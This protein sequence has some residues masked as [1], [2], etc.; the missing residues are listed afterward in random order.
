MNT[1]IRNT[2]K[3]V[4]RTTKGIAI[5]LIGGLLIWGIVIIKNLIFF[6]QTNDAQ[7]EAYVVPINAKVGGY[8]KKVYFHDNQIVHTGDTLLII[9]NSEYILHKSEAEAALESA[10]SQVRVLDANE[11]TQKRNAEVSK[12]QIDAAKAKMQRQEQEYLRFKNLLKEE[13]TTQQQFDNVKTA[14]DIATSEYHTTL[15]LYNA[16]IEK[17]NDVKVQREASLSEI[18]RRAAILNRN[19]LDVN[20]TVITAPY[21]GRLGKKTIQEGQLLQ[22]GQ[23]ITFIVNDDAGKWI[24]ANFMETQVGTFRPGQEVLITIDAFPGEEFHGQIES[25]SP[26]TGSRYSLLPPDNST[27]NFVKITQRIPVRIKL[28]DDKNKTLYLSAGMNANVSVSK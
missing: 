5:L 17:I 6:E 25:L 10:N 1:D 22:P 2:D 16:S 12:S 3:I 7:V 15:K 20:Y 21:N 8:I 23:T 11:N 4:I 19:K 9:D 13:S 14:L 24:A 18:K 28:T 26:T 27:G